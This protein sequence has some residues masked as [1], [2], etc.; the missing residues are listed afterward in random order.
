MKMLLSDMVDY[1]IAFAEII[2]V[3]LTA[4]YNF[5]NY[6]FRRCLRNFDMG[7]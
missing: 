5:G 7:I 6:T 3:V 2:F 1:N 4:L